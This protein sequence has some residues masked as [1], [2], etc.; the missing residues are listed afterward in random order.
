M[1]LEN[2]SQQVKGNYYFIESDDLIN[3]TDIVLDSLTDWLNL[4]T[5]LNKNYSLFENT[6]K[7]TYGDPSVNIK[8][9]VLEKTKGH[10][11][12]VVPQHILQQGKIKY[13]QCKKILLM[14]KS[15]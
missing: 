3:N 7:P 13:D 8:S 12:I 2:F 1:Q 4:K 11:D 15:Q 14:N 6:G 5:P 10:P 9:G